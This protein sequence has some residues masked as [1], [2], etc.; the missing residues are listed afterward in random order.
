MSRELRNV[1]PLIQNLV[2][3]PLGVRYGGA[4]ISL[5][6]NQKPLQLLRRHMGPTLRVLP[7][8]LLHV[9]RRLSLR[10][11]QLPREKTQHFV[12]VTTHF[13]IF[14][15]SLQNTSKN[16][17]DYLVSEDGCLLFKH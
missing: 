7:E 3:N 8:R 9:R 1:M 17:D 11:P 15:V 6:L 10:D 16:V 12:F 4:A 14:Q 5:N 13:E 2:H